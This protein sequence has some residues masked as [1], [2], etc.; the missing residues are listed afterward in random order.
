MKTYSRFTQLL[1]ITMLLSSVVSCAYPG[2]NSWQSDYGHG[3]NSSNYSS[4][5]NGY[6][7]DSH[8]DN[9]RRD[10][11]RPPSVQQLQAEYTME[12][13]RLQTEYAQEVKKEQAEYAM[14]KAKQQAQ[15]QLTGRTDC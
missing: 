7:R 2:R 8:Y 1:F 9:H 12:K 11:N 15:C 5:S 3:S 13:A 4:S 10:N 6:G 14:E